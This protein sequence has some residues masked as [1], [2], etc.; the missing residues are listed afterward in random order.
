MEIKSI[1]QFKGEIYWGKII[2]QDQMLNQWVK[3]GGTILQKGG[4]GG[5]RGGS[6]GRGRGRGRGG[7]GPVGDVSLLLK[8]GKNVTIA[9][10]VTV[11]SI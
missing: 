9:D 5:G 7:G 2:P 8:G 3:R 11:F 1:Q 10:K 6:Q 4:I